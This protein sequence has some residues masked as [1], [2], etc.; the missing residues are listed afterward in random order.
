MRVNIYT[1]HL[2]CGLLSAC[3]AFQVKNEEPISSRGD[4]YG[5]LAWGLVIDGHDADKGPHAYHGFTDALGSLNFVLEQAGDDDL[6]MELILDIHRHCCSMF[7]FRDHDQIPL[8]DW[9]PGCFKSMGCQARLDATETIPPSL[10]SIKI[11]PGGCPVLYALPKVMHNESE[12]MGGL[13]MIL[14][15]YNEA[16]RLAPPQ[17]KPQQTLILARFLKQLA[18]LHPFRDGNARLRTLIAQRE[19]RHRGVGRGAFMYNNNRD[20]YFISDETYAAKIDEGIQMADLAR[21]THQNPWTDH[22][23]VK[24]HLDKFPS[25]GNCHEGGGWGSVAKTVASS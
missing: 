4:E 3:G 7:H 9:G 8:S 24:A 15:T 13:Q 6:T 25:P 1:A 22:A 5:E 19:I 12:I 17:D 20:V 11:E 18:W 23:H 14:N 21:E 16:S 10:V 2:W